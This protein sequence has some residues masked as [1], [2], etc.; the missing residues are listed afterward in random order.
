[1]GKRHNR[2]RTRSRPRHRDGSKAHS[3][4][5]MRTLSSDTTSSSLSSM[6]IS[7]TNLPP[8]VNFLPYN[9]VAAAPPNHWH[10]TYSAWQVRA[11]Y[12]QER[13][14][15]LERHRVRFFGGEVG[16]D[17]SLIEPMLKVVTDL[18]DGMTD[19]EDPC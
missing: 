11:R 14:R 4:P 9:V 16:D 12:E 15:A 10:Q 2:K 5:H 7:S 6:S 1:M 3:Q 8:P 19:F 18:F 17:T 13:E